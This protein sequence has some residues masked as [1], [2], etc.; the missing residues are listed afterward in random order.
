MECQYCKKSFSTKPNLIAHQKKTKYCL[1]IQEKQPQV[2]HICKHCNKE[3]NI[4]LSYDRHILSHESNE[5]FM[6]SQNEIEKLKY[7]NRNMQE[8]INVKDIEIEYL[9]QANTNQINEIRDYK[10]IVENIA[11]KA[12]S[13]PTTVNNNTVNYIQVLKNK[14][15]LTHYHQ[16]LWLNGITPSLI[17][18]RDIAQ[19]WGNHLLNTIGDVNH[20]TDF[21]RK[22][23][24]SKLGVDVRDNDI[25][26]EIIL[27]E[28]LRYM[29]D[30]GCTKLLQFLC[31][32]APRIK[33][34]IMELTRNE[35]ESVPLDEL[36]HYS[37][38]IKMMEILSQGEVNSDMAGV[39]SHYLVN[40]V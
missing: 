35:E 38:Q 36:G 11:A 25:K 21:G 31:T 19:A 9:K 34:K 13:K 27:R 2:L 29:K 24:V 28:G 3:F 33:D 8:M 14:P 30:Y 4:K 10:K 37:K 32:D 12:V 20:L 18:D 22:K 15:P 7:I 26:G 1:K 17:K 5:E 40:A 23:T 6:K 39:I 16:E